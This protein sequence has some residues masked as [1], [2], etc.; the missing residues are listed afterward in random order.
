MVMARGLRKCW[1]QPVFFDFDCQMTKDILFSV[2]LAIQNVGFQ[3]VAVVC[4]MGPT[5]RKLWKTL[6]VT[7]GKINIL[8]IVFIICMYT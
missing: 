2:I 1:K 8:T 3:V 6:D 4:D 5:N 7:V